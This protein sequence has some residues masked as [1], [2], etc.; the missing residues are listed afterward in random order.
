MIKPKTK[1]ENVGGAADTAEKPPVA[2]APKG[3][4]RSHHSKRT[5]P[6][7]CCVLA[8]VLAFSTCHQTGVIQPPG[9][10]QQGATECRDGRPYACGSNAWRPIG[11]YACATLGANVSCCRSRV[12]AVAACLPVTECEAR[13]E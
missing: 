5:Q 11:D 1:S 10:C 2:I 4:R 7:C 9:G 8:S 13:D 3:V 6:L 12:N